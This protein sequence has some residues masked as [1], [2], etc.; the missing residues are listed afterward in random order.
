MSELILTESEVLTDQTDVI[1]S[2]SIERIV[3]GRNAA[4]TQI[5]AL[6]HQ[7]DAISTLTNSIGGGIAKDWGMRPGH[8]YDCWFTEKPVLG[9][10]YPVRIATITL[11]CL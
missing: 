3:T 2:T 11:A 1:C 10:N 9:D 5:E 7:L 4:L 8:R 6:I